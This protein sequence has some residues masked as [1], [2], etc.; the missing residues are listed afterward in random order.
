ME[1]DIKIKAIKVSEAIKHN[2]NPF[3]DH[4]VITIDKGRKSLIIGSTKDVLVNVETS[5]IQA[6]T[7]LH[8]YKEVDKEEF[9]KFYKSEISSLFDLTKPGLKVFGYLLNKLP[10]N[11]CEVYLYMPELMEYCGYRQK[12]LVY[13]GLSEL[14][15]ANIIAMS[16]KSNIWYINPKIIFNGDRIAFVKEYRISNKPKA[17]QLKA[18][19]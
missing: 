19:F 14:I 9:V 4:N 7:M 3:L 12:N 11:D 5:E 16:Y 2:H 6:V 1:E 17:L 15:G 13:K 18:E 8:K 10:Q